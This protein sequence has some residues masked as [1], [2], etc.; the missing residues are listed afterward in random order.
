MSEA[1]NEMFLMINPDL[2]TRMVKGQPDTDTLK[3]AADGELLLLRVTVY[4]AEA[5]QVAGAPAKI[6]L[7]EVVENS[8][9]DEDLEDDPDADIT[10]DVEWSKVR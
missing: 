4:S 6:E 5:A 3:A 7:A 10:Y 1:T 8:P 9:S 2:D